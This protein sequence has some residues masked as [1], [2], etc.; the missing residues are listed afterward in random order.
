MVLFLLDTLFS[1]SEVTG[2]LS[3]LVFKQKEGTVKHDKTKTRTRQNQKKKKLFVY[4]ELNSCCRTARLRPLIR[5]PP[6][7]SNGSPSQRPQYTS[8]SAWY[9]RKAEGGPLTTSTAQSYDEPTT[10]IFIQHGNGASVG[11]GRERTASVLP[12]MQVMR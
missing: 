2:I 5:H 3:W 6:R 8:A 4:L 7:T 9:A 11:P 10:P 1:G 12:V